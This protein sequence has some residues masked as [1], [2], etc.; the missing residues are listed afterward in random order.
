[1]CGIL[2]AVKK[3]PATSATIRISKPFMEALT[4]SRVLAYLSILTFLI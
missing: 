1:L 3:Y 2:A 4:M